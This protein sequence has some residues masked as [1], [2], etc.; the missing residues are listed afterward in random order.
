MT[1]VK[2]Q[3]ISK[4]LEDAMPT[5]KNSLTRSEKLDHL[6]RAEQMRADGVELQI[7]EEWLEVARSSW[8]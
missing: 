3:N 1:G 2:E 6:A 8:T 7:R 4:I 5:I